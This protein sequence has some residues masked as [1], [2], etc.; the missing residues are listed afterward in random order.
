MLRHCAIYLLLLG[1]LLFSSC[2]PENKSS[3]RPP[4]STDT[5]GGSVSDEDTTPPSFSGEVHWFS[6]G[7]SVDGNILLNENTANTIYLR[8]S[9]IDSFLRQNGNENESFCLVGSYNN[10]DPSAKKNLRAFASPI[11]FN[12]FSSGSVERLLKINIP[13]QTDNSSTC[14]GNAY[15]FKQGEDKVTSSTDQ[16]LSA[17]SAFSPPELCPDCSSIVSST[18]V[19]LYKV[20]NAG[21]G[22]VQFI[23]R[24]QLNLESLGLRIDVQSNVTAPGGSCSNS[25]CSAKN[26]DCCLDGQ[27]VN[28]GVEKPNA[29]QDPDY[30]AA[31]NDILENPTN[32]INY[33]NIFY[34]CPNITQPDPDDD[35]SGIIIDP[36]DQADE[37]LETQI[38]DYQCLE[39][40]K[41]RV[42]N[43]SSLGLERC[44][45]INEYIQVRNSVWDRCG[46]EAQP[47]PTDPE[48]PA[49]PDF[50]LKLLHNDDGQIAQ[51]QCLIPD[52][53]V[54]TQPFQRLDINV[55][56][57]S[58]PHRF[59]SKSGVNFD[60]VTK[61]NDPTVK[62]EGQKF[63]Y[64]DESGKT[65]PNEGTGTEFNMNSILGQ[66]NIALNKAHPAKVIP[67]EFDRTY[68]IGAR[69][70]FYT[71]CPSCSKDSWFSAFTSHPSSRQGTGLQ[72]TGH[73]TSRDIYKNNITNGNYEDTIFGRACWVPPTMIPFTHRPNGDLNAQRR[74][75]LQTQ[76]ALYVNGYQRDWYGF[77][78][79]ALIGSF[80]GVK[81][82]AIGK[83]RK[84]VAKSEKLFLAINAPFA[85]LAENTDTIVEVVADQS[86]DSVA[87]HDYD[88]ELL[89]NDPRQNSGATCQ[90]YHSCNVDSDCIAK[91]GWEYACADVSRYKTSWP[92]HDINAKELAGEEIA[93][94]TVSDFIQNHSQSQNQKRCVY[95]GAGSICK[96][97]FNNGVDGRLK[98]QF[99]C[100][101]NFHCA[102]LGDNIFNDRVTRTPAI[103]EQVL[104]GQGADVLGRP[105]DYI[106]ANKTLNNEIRINIQHNAQLISGNSSDFG[107]CRPGRNV[108]NANYIDRHRTADGKNRTDYISQI[109]TCNSSTLNAFRIQ[110]CPVI[111]TREG[112]DTPVGDIIR[113]DNPGRLVEEQNM[114]GAESQE[115]N[116]KGFLESSFKEIEGQALPSL[117]DLLSPKMA[118]D[119]CLRRAGSICHTDLDCGPNRLH[120]E[121]A[122]F[123]GAQ[124]FGGTTAEKQF[125]EEALV[126]SQGGP[127]PLFGDEDFYSYDLTQNR[128]VR[129]VGQELTMYTQ[130]DGQELD[131][132]IGQENVNLQVTQLP[133]DD[134]R[135]Y[136]RYS[137]YTSISDFLT[138]HYDKDTLGYNPPMVP[139]TN[140]SSI[141]YLKHIFQWR[142][143]NETGQNTC[144]GG[145]FVRKFADAS[146]DWSKITRLQLDPETFECL[147][148]SNPLVLDRNLMAQG[149]GNVNNYDKEYDRLCRAPADGGCV[150]IPIQQNNAF[151]VVPP[152]NASTSVKRIDTTPE[153]GTFEQCNAHVQELNTDVP[154]QPV[155]YSKYHNDCHVNFLFNDGFKFYSSMYLP[156]YVLGISALENA[157]AQ[158]GVNFRMKYFDDQEDSVGV[159]DMSQ[160]SAAVKSCLESPGTCGFSNK[161]NYM[162]V[163]GPNNSDPMTGF[164]EN[165]WCVIEDDDGYDVLHVKGEDNFNGG[166]WQYAGVEIP[167]IPASGQLASV[168]ALTP[169]NDLYYL[170]KFARLELLGIPQIIHEP[171]YCNDNSNKLLDGIFDIAP[172]TKTQFESAARDFS[173]SSSTAKL[174]DIYDNMLEADDANPNGKFVYQDKIEL[175]KIF[176]GHEFRCC[177]NL[178][179][180]V[181]SADEC[182]SGFALESEEN[183]DQL[184]CRLPSRA[185]LNVYL[186]RFVSA[187]GL[188]SD[189]PL[190]GLSDEDFIP[191][192]GEPKLR[193]STYDKIQALGIRFCQNNEVRRG[194]T[195][196]F[197]YGEPNNGFFEQQGSLE[198]SRMYSIIDSTKDADTE[199][200]LGTV[201]FLEGYRWSHHIYCL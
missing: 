132:G 151:E 182:C 174:Q 195:T 4:A 143:L 89:P 119:A 187:E 93:P 107:I 152:R 111:E 178:G 71:P 133:V 123:F 197:F 101:P 157:D 14:S 80:D 61:I 189:L 184:T 170:T 126:C 188:G 7:Q 161:T 177:R 33:P 128:C 23:G 44:E 117:V 97:D 136:K 162:D 57:R 22:I 106:G 112:E 153:E 103:L 183:D 3:G 13:N 30:Q 32:Y 31:M 96:R 191:E 156:M 145:G 76:A 138:T 66:F 79:G 38:E 98:K 49:C 45:N 116:T 69:S 165:T 34:I 70:G 104:F 108:N 53:S 194:S 39:E 134:P 46:C 147:N 9:A 141:D 87:E 65:Q 171:L 118:R 155:A 146:Q 63:F 201:R 75:R 167:F 29:T 82:F 48:E 154:Y 2:V 190:G 67:V 192:T 122:S 168:D 142:T 99:S 16:V 62:A 120:A 159:Q 176:S 19:D 150:Q 28:D 86:Q 113:D 41:K 135:G 185:N 21:S 164:P 186:N 114:C 139:I 88:F 91:L 35:D 20:D 43:F 181:S 12:N 115:V 36:G 193:R 50:G 1:G 73:T 8:G 94:A 110:G 59:Y 90:F 105:R 160:C 100:A 54:G 129:E 180:V 127:T 11:T 198:E 163:I 172:Q 137:R 5:Q 169:G 121:Q 25:E 140:N 40:G 81:W 6:S 125:W 84:V 72:A 109:G 102:S 148:Y 83:G 179:K 78:K 158:P 144:S 131:P 26:F 56:N 130:V 173:S 18:R 74:N 200:D 15:A 92:K 58:A 175:P 124:E 52:T 64:L 60:D 17:Q 85:D 166:D 51:V 10:H 47:F 149:G 199:N 95:R 42:P 24:D 37:L 196:G 55:S 27:C 68:T 77:N